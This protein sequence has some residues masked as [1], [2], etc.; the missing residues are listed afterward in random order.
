MASFEEMNPGVT[1]TDGHCERRA[2]GLPDT[3]ATPSAHHNRGADD[4]CAWVNGAVDGGSSYNE[5]WDTGFAG[6]GDPYGISEYTSQS[7]H[8]E[9]VHV[10][11]EVPSQADADRIVA[12]ADAEMAERREGE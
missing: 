11:T 6:E 2:L 12:E 5:F 8:P 7:A 10:S 3:E 4:P 1:K 9:A